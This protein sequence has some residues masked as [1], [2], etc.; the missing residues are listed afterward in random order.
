MDSV[1]QKNQNIIHQTISHAAASSASDFSRKYDLHYS[2]L[3]T[4]AL[5][6]R[7]N[8]LRLAF[9]E[10]K[11]IITLNIQI[12][13]LF[14]IVLN[15]NILFHVFASSMTIHQFE[16]ILKISSEREQSRLSA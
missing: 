9:V 3:Q 6:C 10:D 15:R 16:T 5:T 11:L 4:F 7:D 1:P 2:K 8:V 14:A 13:P 12:L